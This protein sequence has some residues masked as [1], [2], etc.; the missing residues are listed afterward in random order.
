MG[1]RYVVDDNECIGGERTVTE[2]Q[3]FTPSV[4]N[5]AECIGRLL[6][7]LVRENVISRSDAMNFAQTGARDGWDY[8]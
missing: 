3:A 7:K 5:A 6:V 8:K 2:L 4:E 1:H